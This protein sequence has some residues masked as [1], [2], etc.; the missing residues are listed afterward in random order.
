MLHRARRFLRTVNPLDGVAAESDPKGGAAGGDPREM[1]SVSSWRDQGVT[2]SV[3]TM[4]S[5]A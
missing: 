4:P 1:A 5:P 2:V 3:P